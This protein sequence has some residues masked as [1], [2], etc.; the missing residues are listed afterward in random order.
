MYLT[1]FTVL[2]RTPPANPVPSHQFIPHP[3]RR[4][5]HPRSQPFNLKV[6]HLRAR[7]VNLRGSPVLSQFC[8]LH[9]VLHRGPPANPVDNQRHNQAVCPPSSR[10]VGR[11]VSP[12]HSLPHSLP[13]NLQACR[14]HSLQHSPPR[15]QVDS[16]PVALRASHLLRRQLN[17]ALGPPRIHRHIPQCNHP[18]VPVRDRQRGLLQHHYR[19]LA[20]GPVHG[21]PVSPPL[22]PLR[23]LVGF[24]QHS[25]QVFP[26]CNLLVFR[27]TSQQGYHPVSPQECPRLSPQEYQVQFQVLLPPAA[28]LH[29]PPRNQVLGQVRSPA[30]RQRHN[31]VLC[32]P[33]SQLRVQA[34]TPR[35]GLQHSQVVHHLSSHP[36]SPPRGPQLNPQQ[37]PALSLVCSPPVCQRRSHP[38]SRAPSRPVSRL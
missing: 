6:N 9:R 4:G 10:T 29:S 16:R 31:P 30:M 17:Q 14:A 22:D 12:L 32:L 33:H 1:S 20:Q 5:N 11:Q 13:W 26:A 36:V 35:S 34:H 38:S 27:L 23:S 25:P 7:L 15:G 8:P 2:P 21:Q 24:L 19:C 37:D 18:V 3:S 28:H